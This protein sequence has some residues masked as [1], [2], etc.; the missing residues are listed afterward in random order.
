[1]MT[2]ARAARVRGGLGGERRER[3]LDHLGRD[4][5]ADQRHV[6][7]DAVQ[8]PL[9]LAH[10]RAERSAMTARLVRQLHGVA[11]H[12]HAQ[13]REAGREAGRLQ[14]REQAPLEARLQALDDV[15]LSDRPVRRDDDC[16]PAACTSL[17]VWKNS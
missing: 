3:L 14:V 13:D 15:E 8:V 4:D 17:K 6:G 12:L 1:M 5:A 11:G 16:F 10:A 7:D 2:S 9:E